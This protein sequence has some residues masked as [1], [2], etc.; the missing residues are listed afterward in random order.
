M[1][2]RLI[3]MEERLIRM[4]EKIDLLLE[5]MEKQA[6]L[7]ERLD[8]HI[9]FIERIYTQLHTPLNY[10][11]NGILKMMGRSTSDELEYVKN[12]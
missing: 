7:N 10:F 6:P 5:K 9:T 8:R 1:E 2:E 11:K 4:E 3:H 12:E